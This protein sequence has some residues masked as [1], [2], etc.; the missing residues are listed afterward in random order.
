MRASRPRVV[1]GELFFFMQS[2]I[3]AVPAGIRARTLAEFRDGLERVDSSA[4]Y[5]HV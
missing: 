1:Y 3:L 5:F 4:I 2:R